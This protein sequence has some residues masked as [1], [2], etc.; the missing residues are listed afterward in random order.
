MADSPKPQ[1]NKNSIT[2][3]LIVALGVCL[4][5]ATAVSAT[6]VFL[7]PMQEA[8]KL[9]DKKK[10]ILEAAGLMEDGADVNELFDQRIIDRIIDLDTGEDVTDQYDDPGLFDQIDVA[11]SNNL[12]ESE[13]LDDDPA[14][15]KRRENHSHVYIVKTSGDDDSPLMY[16]FPIRGKGLWSIL[17]GFIALDADLNTIRG[18]T[19]YDH[20]ETPGLGGEVDNP[21]WKSHWTQDKKLFDEQGNVAIRLV[22]ADW[23][24]SPYTI[25]ALT[26]ATI[27]CRGVEKMLNFWMSETGFGPYLDRLRSEQQAADVAVAGANHG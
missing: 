21:E 23:Q 24:S 7:L 27:T 10:N 17:K 8:N 12:Q 3:T 18:I 20:A 2:N 25:D 14:T 22:K 13:K 19:Y 6:H 16:V 1:Y 4:V 5:C 15:I 26:G 11:E 9:K